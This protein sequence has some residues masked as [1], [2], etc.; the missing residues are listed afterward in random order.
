MAYPNLKQSVWLVVLFF[1]F[2]LTITVPFAVHGMIVGQELN[3]NPYV[4]QL[5]ILTGFILAVL[6][7]K[8]RT[9]R[10]LSE[11]LPFKAVSLQLYIPLVVAVVGLAI[12]GSDLGNL[13]R[14]LISP[15]EGMLD[16]VGDRARKEKPFPLRFYAMVI[17]A[18]LLK[19]VLFRGVILGGLLAHRTPAKAIV[20]SAVLFAI[21]H[22]D[23]WQFP[24]AFLLGIVF[25]WI[26]VQTGSLLPAIVGHALNNFLI[27]TASHLGV[28]GSTG[29]T[30]AGMTFSWWMHGCGI[31][32]A[33]IGLWWFNGMSMR[34]G[35]QVATPE[36]REQV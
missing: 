5:S 14:H 9:D 24:A 31:I 34:G 32:L 11:I 23:P 30:G 29:G 18:P 27:V 33:L 35:T 3:Q 4:I 1:L 26:V 19:E 10:T 7:A 16:V 25:A 6:Y 2:S 36:G 21:I 15:P 17:Q 22:I 28:L 12:V 20:W 13:L 8:R